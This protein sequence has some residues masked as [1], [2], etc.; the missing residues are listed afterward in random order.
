MRTNRYS[1]RLSS[2]IFYCPAETWQFTRRLRVTRLPADSRR[3][4]QFPE[5]PKTKTVERRVPIRVPTLRTDNINLTLP[6]TGIRL[7]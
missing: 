7:D 3:L 6:L 5:T 4:V 1:V 2:G